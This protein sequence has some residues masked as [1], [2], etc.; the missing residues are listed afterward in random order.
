VQYKL[1]EVDITRP[2]NKA[3]HDKYKYDI[4]VLHLQGDFLTKHRLALQFLDAHLEAY[5]KSGA[6]PRVNGDPNP[7]LP[8]PPTPMS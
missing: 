4:P 1:V 6:I 8:R 2:E 5:Y 7:D 3:W